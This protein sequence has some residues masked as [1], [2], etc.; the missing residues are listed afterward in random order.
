VV[1]AVKGAGAPPAY[2]GQACATPGRE[3]ESLSALSLLVVEVD[4]PGA[5]NLTGRMGK[6]QNGSATADRGIPMKLLRR[7]RSVRCAECGYACLR[8][9]RRIFLGDRDWGGAMGKTPEYDYA[10]EFAELSLPDRQHGLTEPPDLRSGESELRCYRQAFP[11]WEDLKRAR[12]ELE[13]GANKVDG[14][15][16]SSAPDDLLLAA[17]KHVL[18]AE[19]DCKF[20]FPFSPGYGPEL[21][22]DLEQRRRERTSER[23]WNF[24]SV[25]FG[26]ALVAIPTIIVALAK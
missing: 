3:G 14:S 25:A 15:E 10:P 17:Y 22:R 20:W 23:L 26:A 13:E 2:G 16:E 7:S 24:A 4:A 21:H 6:A 9:T 12:K 1:D 18:T 19:R 8:K 11:L 5:G